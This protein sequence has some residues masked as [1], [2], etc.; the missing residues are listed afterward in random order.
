MAAAVVAGAMRQRERA[1]DGGGGKQ[2]P[3]RGRGRREGEEWETAEGG[4]SG[5]RL[6]WGRGTAARR[7]RAP[8]SQ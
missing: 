5:W 4:D 7:P 6:P 2:V 8:A 1:R 3:R